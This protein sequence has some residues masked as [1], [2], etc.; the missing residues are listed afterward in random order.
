[1]CTHVYVLTIAIAFLAPVAQQNR[2]DVINYNIIALQFGAMHHH[3]VP[4]DHQT[5]KGK[6]TYVR[7]FFEAGFEEAAP[8]RLLAGPL[9][10]V[11]AGFALVPEDPPSLL[12]LMPLAVQYIFR[13]TRKNC[14]F[15]IV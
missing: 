8:A 9:A 5:Q 7:L 13:A 4:T 12:S 10:L 2:H 11:F 3:R 15:S 6:L 1:M 14:E